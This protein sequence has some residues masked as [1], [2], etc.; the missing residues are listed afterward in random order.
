MSNQTKV[1][2]SVTVIYS[3]EEIMIRNNGSINAAP[4]ALV[5]GALFQT[6]G[7]VVF[8]NYNTPYPKA[9]WLQWSSKI[10]DWGIQS[11]MSGD[12]VVIKAITSDTGETISLFA[13]VKNTISNGNVN[14]E[15]FLFLC[16]GEAPRWINI[17]Q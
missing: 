8:L 1:P 9:S 13:I 2:A 14:V 6:S 15:P 11:V 10:T 3:T 12:L 7:K 17:Q 16:Q 4:L 5:L